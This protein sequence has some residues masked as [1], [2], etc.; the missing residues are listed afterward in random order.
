MNPE[1]NKWYYL[2]E[3]FPNSKI[4]TAIRMYYFTKDMS[5][6]YILLCHYICKNYYTN[7]TTSLVINDAYNAYG[8]D[9]EDL[10]PCANPKKIYEKLIF[11]YKKE[12]FEK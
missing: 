3:I 2:E 8:T 9:F 11:D 10:A 7:G 5:E 1:L 4:H 12:Y 6:D